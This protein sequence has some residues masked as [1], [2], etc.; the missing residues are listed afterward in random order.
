MCPW[1]YYL[2]FRCVI[3]YYF[4]LEMLWCQISVDLDYMISVPLSFHLLMRCSCILL[5]M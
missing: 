3:S 4:M 1:I 5:L 2:P